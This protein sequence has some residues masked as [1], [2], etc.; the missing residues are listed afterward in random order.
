M[1][2]AY[3]PRASHLSQCF[4]CIFASFVCLSHVSLLRAKGGGVWGGGG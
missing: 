1:A 2:H 3:G 4:E